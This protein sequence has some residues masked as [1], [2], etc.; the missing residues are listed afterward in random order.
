MANEVSYF[1]TTGRTL[2]F[3][4]RQPD[5][6]L[7][8]AANQAMTE[9][10]TGFYTAT[11]STTLESG[12]I[13]AISDSVYGIIAQGEYQFAS[14][15]D[16]IT[17]IKAKTDLIELYPFIRVT[18][19]L[20]PN[21]AGD[22]FIYGRNDYGNV[23]KSPSGFLL[24]TTDTGFLITDTSGVTWTRTDP[25]GDINGDYTPDTGATGTATASTVS[26][27]AYPITL[28]NIDNISREP[29]AVID[30]RTK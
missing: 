1:F 4:A 3:T 15:S 6:T 21:V 27:V 12:D 18:G 19:T 22:Y 5:G 24:E 10:A 7:R 29:V 8:G 16:D 9:A 2:T 30:M 28:Q 23:F 14:L 13:V 11:P 20:T 17:D 26:T 25:L